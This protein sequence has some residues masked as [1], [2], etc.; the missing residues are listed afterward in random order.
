M[1]NDQSLKPQRRQY[2]LRELVAH[3]LPYSVHP[4]SEYMQRL[5]VLE[6]ELVRK[7]DIAKTIDSEKRRSLM[8]TLA[9]I[10]NDTAKIRVELEAIEHENSIDGMNLHVRN[11]N[12][13]GTL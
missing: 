6:H 7:E 4:I 12:K 5:N 9:K 3:K 2:K 11:K 13:N 10:R 8:T 1:E